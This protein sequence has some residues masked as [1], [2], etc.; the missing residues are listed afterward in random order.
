MKRLAVLL[1]LISLPAYGQVLTPVSSW[2]VEVSSSSIESGSRF[3]ET[4]N[5]ARFVSTVTAF[6]T[7]EISHSAGSTTVDPIATTTSSLMLP[8]NSPEYFRIPGNGRI[9]VIS[10]GPA[11]T[12]YISEMSK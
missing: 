7:F 8:A 4:A 1:A 10:A 9:A 12:L 5:I 3:S 2:T 6:L 11:G